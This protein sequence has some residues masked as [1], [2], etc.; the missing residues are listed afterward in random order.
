MTTLSE[1]ED[2]RAALAAMDEEEERRRCYECYLEALPQQ[3]LN[4]LDD[5]SWE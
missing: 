1:E 2:E 5:A 3:E 4:E